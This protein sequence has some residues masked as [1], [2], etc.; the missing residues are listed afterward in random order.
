MGMEAHSFKMD[1]CS[2]FGCTVKCLLTAYDMLLHLVTATEQR[3]DQGLTLLDIQLRTVPRNL[4]VWA[5]YIGL[6]LPVYGFSPIDNCA[7][8]NTCFVTHSFWF[9]FD[10]ARGL[11]NYGPRATSGLRH[12]F[13]QPA[14]A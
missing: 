2:C 6:I 12:Q 5:R 1:L 11:P 3:K 9:L 4:S 8:T 10:I 7:S 13:F 14:T